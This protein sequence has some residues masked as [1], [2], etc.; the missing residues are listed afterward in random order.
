MA[1][2]AFILEETHR[3]RMN[4]LM[5]LRQGAYHK[6]EVEKEVWVANLL[7]NSRDA[8]SSFKLSLTAHNANTVFPL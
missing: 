4:D 7:R 5:T 8:S 1:S 3:E 2:L 6:E